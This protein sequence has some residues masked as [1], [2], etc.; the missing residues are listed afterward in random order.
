MASPTIFRPDAA[1]LRARSTAYLKHQALRLILILG[2]AACGLL[3]DGFRSPP[4]SESLLRAVAFGLLAGYTLDLA[5]RRSRGQGFLPTRRRRIAAYGPAVVALASVAL[6]L[7]LRRP[8]L[9]EVVYAAIYVAALTELWRLNSVLSWRLATPGALLPGSFALLIAVGT[10]LLKLPVAVPEGDAISWLDAA[11]TATSAVCVTG[12]TV[13]STAAAFTPFGQTVIAVLIQLGGL[14]IILFGSMFALLLGSGLSLREVRHLSSMLND[15]PLVRIRKLVLFIIVSTFAIQLAGA[16][17]MFPL[18]HGELTVAHRAGMS[19]FHA[20]SAYCNAGFDITGDSFVPY[21]YGLIPHLIIAPLI[22]LGGIG[23][24]VM[25]N[26]VQVVRARW[27]AGQLQRR[28]RHG[29]QAVRLDPA[30]MRLSLH[31]RLVLLT[32]LVLYGYGLGAIAVGQ[33]AQ[34]WYPLDAHDLALAADRRGAIAG[35]A[36]TLADAHFMAITAR[37]AG[38]NSMPMD[39]LS[40][41]GQF[42]VMTLMFVGGSPGGTAGGVKTS[43]VA[44]LLLSVVATI[45]ARRE[46]EALGRSIADALIRRAAAIVASLMLLITVATLL[47]TLS[48]PFEFNRVLFEA[49]SAATTTGLSLGIT[50][51]LTGFG[52]AVIIAAMYLGRVGPLALLGS[53]MFRAGR[54]RP[55]RYPHEDVVLG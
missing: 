17:A 47:L 35:A 43:T 46:T 33:V 55:Y 32:T 41:A 1:T 30:A 21:R 54:E 2:A 50:G 23:F 26:I 49:I 7:V 6:W 36:Q 44:L 52:K 19:L 39:E 9:W 10:V 28:L 40:P 11:F 45:T 51:E 5:W 18:W 48:E 37:T 13:R 42:V 14:G 27:R 24:P 34:H 16:A 20:I 15:Q 25:V 38:F 8:W 22:V 3:E 29:P 31:T 53:L 12:L 4:V